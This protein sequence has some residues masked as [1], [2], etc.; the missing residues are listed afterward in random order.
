[1]VGFPEAR[2]LYYLELRAMLLA[3]KSNSA[4]VAIDAAISDVRHK[5]L[6]TSTGSFER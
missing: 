6:W 2:A 3:P 4:Y 1:M 5:G